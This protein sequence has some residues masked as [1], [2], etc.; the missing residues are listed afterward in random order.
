MTLVFQ[1]VNEDGQKRSF[2]SGLTSA[3]SLHLTGHQPL[4]L[5]FGVRQLGEIER[6]R[7]SRGLRLAR[8]P[9]TLA[10]GARAG[11]PKP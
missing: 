5:E 1:Q 9:Q 3:L 4:L 10:F 8:S 7:N 11:L 6:M 2:L